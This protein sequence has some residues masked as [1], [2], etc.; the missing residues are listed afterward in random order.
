MV[1]RAQP[2]QSRVLSVICSSNHSSQSQKQRNMTSRCGHLRC[3]P[4]ISFCQETRGATAYLLKTP[5][6]SFCTA[7]LSFVEE[8]CTKFPEDSQEVAP[9]TLPGLKLVPALWCTVQAARR[10][11]LSLLPQ[12]LVVL[13]QLLNK[14]CD[15]SRLRGLSQLLDAGY[16]NSCGAVGN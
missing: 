5:G 16:V 7:P 2:V 13:G 15:C 6:Q 12:A 11:P 3:L 8:C 9:F 4:L 1:P 14:A 10:L